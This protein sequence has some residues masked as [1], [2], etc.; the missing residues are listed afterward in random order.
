MKCDLRALIALIRMNL[1]MCTLI[2]LV[3]NIWIVEKY[4]VS[5]MKKVEDTRFDTNWN[6]IRR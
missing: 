6:T 4:V 3:V 5:E 2:K 1:F